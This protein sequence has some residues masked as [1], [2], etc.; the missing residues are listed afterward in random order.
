[1]VTSTLENEGKSSCTVN[2]ALALAKNGNNVLLIDG[3]IRKPSIDLIFG[4]KPDKSFNKYYDGESE[5]DEQVV[6]L[7]KEDLYVLLAEADLKRAE[8]MVSSEKFKDIINDAREEFDYV[9]IDTSPCRNLNEPM[10]IDEYVD[11][12]IF[13]IK[14]NYAKI[15]Y[16]NETIQ[17]L[18][19]VKGNVIGAIYI[20]SINAGNI[21]SRIGY[22]YGRYGSRYGYNRYSG[23]SKEKRS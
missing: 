13:V 12:S 23:Y 16:I 18:A 6:H 17:R 20:S 19:A 21:S 10:I 7:E 1:M 4:L 15:E 5:W 22:G 11:A 8:E 2:L 3:D 9:I 14:Q